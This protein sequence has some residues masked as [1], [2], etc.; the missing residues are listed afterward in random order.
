MALITDN[1]TK[2]KFYTGTKAKYNEATHGQ[3]VYFCTDAPQIHANGVWTGVSDM[4][5][6]GTTLAIKTLSLIHI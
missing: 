1:T 2:I 3:G 6:A 5:I 4:K